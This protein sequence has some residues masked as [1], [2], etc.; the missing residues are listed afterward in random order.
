MAYVTV[1]VDIELDEFSTEE[2]INELINRL[3]KTARNSTAMSQKQKDRLRVELED[4]NKK[5]FDTKS[6]LPIVSLNDRM[7]VEHLRSVWDK[8]PPQE[9]ECRLP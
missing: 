2:I 7:K 4:L 8:Y 6:D 3:E 9:L 1:D 5:L